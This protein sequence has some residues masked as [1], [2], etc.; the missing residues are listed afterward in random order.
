LAVHHL[1]AA[2][3]AYFNGR[4]LPQPEA[5]LPLHDAGFVFGATATDLVRTFRH[6]LFRL[7][8]HIA[9]FRQSCTLTRIPLLLTDEQTKQI[10]EQLVRDNAKLLKPE[11]DLALVM[12]AT[13][14]PI[15]YYAGLEGDPGDGP[16][17]FGMHTFPLPFARDRHFFSEGVHLVVPAT[18]QIPSE[19]IDPHAKQRSRLHWWKAGQEARLIEEGALALLRDTEGFI[20]ETA[21]ANFLLVKEGVVYGPPRDAILGGISLLTVQEIC[22]EMSIGFQERQLRLEDCLHAD[23]AML[24]GTSFCLAGVSRI[25]GQPI[26]WPG[27]VFHRLLQVWSR[28]VGLDIQAQI[29]SA[30]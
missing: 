7:D 18:R 19:C 29:L 28:R 21:V 2:M 30:D 8:D 22:R 5:H 15:G 10:A 24:T 6:R 26:P 25:N 4:F 1:Q 20:T 27:K 14:G 12:F 23:E 16:P 13:P 17:T 3:L 9:R 11:Q